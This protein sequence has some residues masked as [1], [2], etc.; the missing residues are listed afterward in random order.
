VPQ[1]FRA[2]SRQFQ[3]YK[4][5]FEKP[6][7]E[8]LVFDIDFT[9]EEFS[10]KAA[11]ELLTYFHKDAVAKKSLIDMWSRFTALEPTRIAGMLFSPVVIAHLR[12][13]LKAKYDT[14]FED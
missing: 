11:H 7:S 13:E 2:I 9:H 10:L 4:I 3:F 8:R 12:K 14:K 5:L 6:I 1:A